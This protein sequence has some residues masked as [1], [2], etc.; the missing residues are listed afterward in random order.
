MP[1]GDHSSILEG[2]MMDKNGNKISLGNFTE[3]TFNEDEEQIEPSRYIRTKMDESIVMTFNLNPCTYKRTFLALLGWKAKGP[4]RGRL[5][6]KLR[7][8][9]YTYE[10]KGST[11]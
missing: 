9:R 5:L 6:K 8:W 3:V 1:F 2:F 11:L 10:Y 4:Y 7:A